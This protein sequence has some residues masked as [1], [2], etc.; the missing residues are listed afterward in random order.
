MRKFKVC[1]QILS[2]LVF[3]VCCCYMGVYLYEYYNMKSDIEIVREA[4]ETAADNTDEEQRYAENGMLVEFYDLYCQNED[5]VGWILIEDTDVNYPVLYKNTD[6]DYYLHRNFSKKYSNGGIPFLDKEC[7]LASPS[8]NLIIYGHNMKNG[9]M[10]APL[11]KYRDADFLAAHKTVMFSNL[12]EKFEYTIISVF[13]TQVDSADEFEY[14]NFIDAD[15][16]EDF[17]NFV[18]TAKKLSIHTIEESAEYGDE[19]LTLSTCSYNRKNERLVVLA[20]RTK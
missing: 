1:M 10:F 16:E 3:V 5:M 17:N 9:T 19:L 4:V 18:T 2:L 11:L 7:S 20:K 6:N 15:S 12:Y 8:D 13:K 14:Y